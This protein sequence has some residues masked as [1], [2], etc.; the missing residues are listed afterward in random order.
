MNPNDLVEFYKTHLLVGISEYVR[1]EKRV[2]IYMNENGEF[3]DVSG[4]TYIYI[5]ETTFYKLFNDVNF[6][7]KPFFLFFHPAMITMIS[8]F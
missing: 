5:G 4:K 6:N 7:Y 8:F 3:V 1:N 2:Y